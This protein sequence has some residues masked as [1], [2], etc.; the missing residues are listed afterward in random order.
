MFGISVLNGYWWKRGNRRNGV[1]GISM[2]AVIVERHPNTN[3]QDKLK[4]KNE[5]NYKHK[6]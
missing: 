6:S 4:A 5:R 3:G 2:L 1:A